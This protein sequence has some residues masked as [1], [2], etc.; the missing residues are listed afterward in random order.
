[1]GVSWLPSFFSHLNSEAK[2][3]DRTAGAVA[4]CVAGGADIIR[5]H[6]VD[7]M[8]KVAMMAEAIWRK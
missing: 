8:H 7:E 4:A 5:V 1:M 6:D 3:Y 2:M